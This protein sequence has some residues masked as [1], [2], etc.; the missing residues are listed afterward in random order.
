M[1]SSR[2]LL[3]EDDYEELLEDIHGKARSNCL[4]NIKDLLGPTDETLH[5][6][7]ERTD[8]EVGESKARLHRRLS[9]ADGTR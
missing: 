1:A 4:P 3:S 9:F 5:D 2:S 6:T 8:T 7:A